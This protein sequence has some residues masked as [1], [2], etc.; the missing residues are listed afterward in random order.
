MNRK[1]GVWLDHKKAFIVITKNS[2]ETRRIITSDMEHYLRYSQ[3]AP[4]DGAPEDTRDRQYWNH[5]A[6][7]YA[8]VIEKIG[9]AKSILIFG[10]GEAKHELKNHLESKGMARNI[11]G[12][13]NTDQLTH[14][15]IIK[16][17]RERFPAK[18]EF[19]LF[20]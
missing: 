14:N 10:P 8:K 3:N 2:G 6:E 9:D 20:A 5:L 16:I 4:G 11:V 1:V 15:Q 12:I 18:S 17:V 7:Y 13:D 19:D